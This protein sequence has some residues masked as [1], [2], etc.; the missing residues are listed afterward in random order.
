M[1]TLNKTVMV[2]LSEDSGPSL[3]DIAAR[4]ERVGTLN[5]KKSAILCYPDVWEAL[6]KQTV[7]D[8]T[9]F[10]RETAVTVMRGD[11]I[12][13]VP[14]FKVESPGECEVVIGGLLLQ[15]YNNIVCIDSAAGRFPERI[16]SYHRLEWGG[17]NWWR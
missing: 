3:A 14:V 10:D 13:G 16:P 12:H 4:A 11:M 8:E 9:D 7:G 17:D 2:A 6:V 5:L 15:G 1:I